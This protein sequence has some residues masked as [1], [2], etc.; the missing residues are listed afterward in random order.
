[1]RS[2]GQG[3]EASNPIASPSDPLR[4]SDSYRIDE[5]SRQYAK[6]DGRQKALEYLRH[7]MLAGDPVPVR[8]VISTVCQQSGINGSWF[9]LCEALVIYVDCYKDEWA[10]SWNDLEPDSTLSAAIA[11]GC[12]RCSDS[13]SISVRCADDLLARIEPFLDGTLLAEVEVAHAVAR[14]IDE[15]FNE[16]FN[17]WFS[18]LM[19]PYILVPGLAFPVAVRDPTVWTNGSAFTPRARRPNL[20]PMD[21]ILHLKIGTDELAYCEVSLDWKFKDAW[22]S[23]SRAESLVIATAHFNDMLSDYE[24]PPEPKGTLAL[25]NLGPKTD[26]DRSRLNT[27]LMQIAIDCNAQVVVFPEYSIRHDNRAGLED[28]MARDNRPLLLV[29]GT[30]RTVDGSNEGCLMVGTADRTVDTVTFSKRHPANFGVL[31]EDIVPGPSRLTV[32]RADDIA[33]AVVI[34]ADLMEEGL[35]N[36]MGMLGVNLLLVPS[37]TDKADLI[38][39][40][41]TQ[42]SFKSQGFGVL[43]VAPRKFYAE[44]ARSW[45]A[46]FLGPYQRDDHPQTYSV[47]EPGADPRRA[48]VWVFDSTKESPTWHEQS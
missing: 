1:M 25:K 16:T 31:K 23:W 28:M 15:E 24:I 17:Q 40:H 32:W 4:V 5:F 13:G 36:L 2:F 34:C 12:K 39:G 20:R 43:A 3:S 21:E 27:E 33:V 47:P 7:V 6:E 37:F 10:A 22:A 18:E 48:G 29:A 38:I 26:A 30:A 46:V 44:S 14:Y 42:V 45:E 11:L 9:A 35:T 19:D 8:D 41:M